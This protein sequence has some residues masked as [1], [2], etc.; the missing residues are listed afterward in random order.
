MNINPKPYLLALCMSANIGSNAT[1]TGNP[2]NIIIATS[3][4]IKYGSFLQKCFLFQLLG[5]LYVGN[6]TYIL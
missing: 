3:S 1:V 6:F 2:Q 5:L 4:G